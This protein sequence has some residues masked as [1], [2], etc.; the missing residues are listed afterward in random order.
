VGW[1]LWL[2][3]RRLFTG[4]DP[5]RS[6]LLGALAALALGTA[7]VVA[8]WLVRQQLT[9]GHAFSQE[10]SH[11]ALA[12]SL[13]E[14]ADYGTSP[15]L[16][17]WLH[18]GLGAILALRVATLWDELHHVTDYLFYPTALPAF[19]GLLVLAWRNHTAL[20]GL[21]SVLVLLLGFAAL[22]PAVAITGGY[23]HS[24]ASVA[25]FLAWGYLAAVYVVARWA[26]GR[27]PLRLSLA[28]AIAAIPALLQVALLALAFPVVGAGAG[29][30]QRVFADLSR[31]LRAHDA[32]V[33]MATQSST[34]YYASGIPSIQLPS[35][36]GP[37]VAYACARHYGAQYLVITGPAGEYP[38]V[39]QA[40]PDPRFALVAETADYQIYRIVAGA[41]PSAAARTVAPGVG[42]EPRPG[43]QP[44]APA[45]PR[46]AR[47]G[48]L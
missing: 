28:P 26:R 22:F 30:E 7:L 6:R 8:P 25:P 48:V 19:A 14:F 43:R 33:V 24:V 20:L 9:F 27:L 37:V 35:A 47:P 32:H 29:H 16:A 11:N 15:T 36:Q 42:A 46:G 4:A 5:V 2:L 38:Q 39:L 34:L 41:A 3:R 31:W 12:F 40:Q 13:D 10:A 44:G 1:W 17:T 18:H 45:P 23:Y 21:L